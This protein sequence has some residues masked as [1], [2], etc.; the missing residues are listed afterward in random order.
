MTTQPINK[1]LVKRLNENAT[2]PTKGSKLAAGWD[3][4]ADADYFV[5]HREQV[6]VGTGIAVGIPPGYYGRI[7][8]RS[9]LAFKQKFNVHAGV[10]DRDFVHEIKVILFNHDHLN[11]EIKKGDRIAQLILE[12]HLEDAEIEEVD[13]LTSTDRCEGVEYG[14]FG[15]TGK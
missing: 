10:I 13:D 3:I 8:P 4:Y 15:S 11:H 14:G 6:V 1:L 9:G 7:A 5:P 12:R 2:L